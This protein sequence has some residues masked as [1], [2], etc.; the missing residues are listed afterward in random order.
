VPIF[1]EDGTHS[2]KMAMK[3]QKNGVFGVKMGDPRLRGDDK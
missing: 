1:V 2:E 3:R